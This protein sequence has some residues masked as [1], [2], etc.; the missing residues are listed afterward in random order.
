MTNLQKRI[1]KC[2]D[3][4]NFLDE[5]DW[6]EKYFAHYN[7]QPN[8]ASLQMFIE[9]DSKGYL[10]AGKAKAAANDLYDHYMAGRKLE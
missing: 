2:L 3:E 1:L 8:L 9:L 4:N 6:L 7:N 10:G 5:H